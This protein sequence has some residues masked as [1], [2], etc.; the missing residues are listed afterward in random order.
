MEKTIFVPVYR[1][2]VAD[3]RRAR[4][5]CGLRQEDV[6]GKLGCTR[7]WLSRVEACQLRLDVVQLVRL[8]RIYGVS[9]SRLAGRLEEE[10][11][12]EDGSLYVSA[13]HHSAGSCLIEWARRP[14][15]RVV[16]INVYC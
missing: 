6:A 11:S 16:L 13:N 2:I 14:A 15:P 7:H 10:L 4:E 3:L 12:E 5:K 1:Q 8:C 9:P